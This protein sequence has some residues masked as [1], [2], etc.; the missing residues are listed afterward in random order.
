VTTSSK[1]SRARR[2]TDP[3]ELPPRST[4]PAPSST[5]AR[6]ASIGSYDERVARGVAL[7]DAAVPGWID[8]IDLE[9]L[10]LRSARLCVAAQLDHARGL[11]YTDA[12]SVWR[13]VEPD[14]HNYQ[15]GAR[16]HGLLLSG[17]DRLDFTWDDAEELDYVRAYAALTDAWRAAIAQRRAAVATRP[18]EGERGADG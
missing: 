3:A 14:P 9:L 11:V 7:L 18:T 2:S 15:D 6:D 17:R 12:A 1:T 8:M 10:S 13:L 16:R 5:V 4:N